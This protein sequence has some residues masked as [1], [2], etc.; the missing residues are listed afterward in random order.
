MFVLRSEDG[1][2]FQDWLPPRDRSSLPKL[3]FTYSLSCSRGFADQ[4]LAESFQRFFKDQ[5]VKTEVYVVEKNRLLAQFSP[6]PRI[7]R[8][9]NQRVNVVDLKKSLRDFRT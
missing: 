1:R 7:K 5:G 3:R 8:L 9:V 2:F 6:E 4:I